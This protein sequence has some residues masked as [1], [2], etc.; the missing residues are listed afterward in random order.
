MRRKWV[1]L[2]NRIIFSSIISLVWDS[3]CGIFYNVECSS[4]SCAQSAPW[5]CIQV[6]WS[7]VAWVASRANPHF[8]ICSSNSASH[9]QL[10]RLS[11]CFVDFECDFPLTAV[12]SAFRVSSWNSQ[13]S[14]ITKY[15][16][17][18]RDIMRACH[19]TQNTKTVWR[20]MHKEMI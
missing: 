14:I 11:L 5:L 4:L 18:E 20:M 12:L 19:A 9:L 10:L 16:M 15:F 6:S 2:V 7:I 13:Q 8:Q 3:V 1:F 17:R